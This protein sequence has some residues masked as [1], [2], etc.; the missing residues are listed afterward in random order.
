MKGRD[1]SALVLHTLCWG[2]LSL[3]P[4]GPQTSWPQKHYEVDE[5]LLFIGYISHHMLK[6]NPL[7]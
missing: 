1:G 7:K 6:I 5:I 3:M 4:Q 2:T